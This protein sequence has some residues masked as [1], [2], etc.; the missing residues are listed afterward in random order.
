MNVQL[1]PDITPLRLK[2]FSL[3]GLKFQQDII[4]QRFSVAAD[5]LS[6][7]IAQLPLMVFAHES[8]PTNTLASLMSADGFEI[9]SAGAYFYAAVASAQPLAALFA[10]PDQHA[11]Q[12]KPVTIS[13]RDDRVW[14]NYYAMSFNLGFS[15]AQMRAS[16]AQMIKLADNVSTTRFLELFDK[17]NQPR[18]SS[19]LFV[20]EGRFGGTFWGQLNGGWPGAFSAY[21]YLPF[22]LCRV[23]LS[24]DSAEALFDG[25]P[26]SQKQQSVRLWEKLHSQGDAGMPERTLATIGAAQSF[27]E[28][29]RVALPDGVVGPANVPAQLEILQ[30]Y[31]QK[32]R[33][34]GQMGNTE[35]K[36]DTPFF[37]LNYL[38][39]NNSVFNLPAY[40]P[41]DTQIH[42][43]YIGAQYQNILEMIAAFDVN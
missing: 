40:N 19:F 18:G 3:A 20:N 39:E 14:R 4:E 17:R 36:A 11:S 6:Y 38:R 8:A 16:I 12:F 25:E 41:D 37:S 2:N 43:Q 35:V 28:T 13:N 22:R 21:S 5:T 42:A 29:S 1:D 10:E 32:I 30:R 15:A 27:F 7:S 26:D 24:K 34:P 23:L 9:D 33:V 31:Q